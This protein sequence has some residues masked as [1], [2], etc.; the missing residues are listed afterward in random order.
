MLS[1]TS[2]FH[3]FFNPTISA[4]DDDENFKRSFVHAIECDVTEVIIR[5]ENV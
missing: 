2:I 3:K 5:N 1:K 4:D